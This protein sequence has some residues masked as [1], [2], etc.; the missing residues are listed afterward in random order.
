MNLESEYKL[1]S[2]KKIRLDKFKPFPVEL[3]KNLDDWFRV[4][5]TYT[6]NAIEGNTLTR[7]ETAMVIEKGTTVSGKTLVEQLEAKNHALAFDFVNTL[8]NKTRTEIAENDILKIHSYILSGIDDVNAGRYR[9]VSV[10]VAGSNVVFPNS[11]KVSELMKN[12]LNWLTSNNT[13]HPIKIASDA[14]LKLVTIHPF[15]DGNGRTARLLMNLILLQNGFPSAIIK[16]EDRL[17][18][19]NSIEKAQLTNDCTDYYKII[20]DAVNRSLDIYLNAL[21]QN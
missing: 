21:E 11:V 7:Q 13:D 5:L 19:I 14:H 17:E 16:N 6:S 18:Y 9:N 15:V 12:Y 20:I 1:L 4:E 3:I 2:D 8:K 10:R